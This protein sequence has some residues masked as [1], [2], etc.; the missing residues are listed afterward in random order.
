MSTQYFE[1][2]L[3]INYKSSFVY[4]G[5]TVM[6]PRHVSLRYFGIAHYKTITFHK[7]IHGGDVVTI[8]HGKSTYARVNYA[9]QS[10]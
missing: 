5:K 10:K 6:S 7:A 9:T 4:C 1:W 8:L 3:K 2:Q